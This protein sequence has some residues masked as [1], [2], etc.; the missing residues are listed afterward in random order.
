MINAIEKIN[1]FTALIFIHLLGIGDFVIEQMI[2]KLKFMQY[3]SAN[4]IT[5]SKAQCTANSHQ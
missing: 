5:Y 2:S 4:L 3:L 1:S